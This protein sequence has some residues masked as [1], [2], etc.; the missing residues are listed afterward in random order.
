MKKLLVL[1]AGATGYVL[2]TRAGRE[3][4]EQ[5]RRQST[6][7]W[8]SEPV[9]HGRDEAGDAAA[10]AAVAAAEAAKH[11]AADAAS[12]AAAKVKHA[13]KHDEPSRVTPPP[14]AADLSAGPHVR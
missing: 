14:T 8:N 13:V 7:V 1:A 5:I 3:R 4:Y 12:A 11:A 10:R 6:K 2:G 9:Q